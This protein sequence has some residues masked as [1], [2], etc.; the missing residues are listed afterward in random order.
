VIFVIT[1]V[2]FVM[3][4]HVLFHWYLLLD[5]LQG[6]SPIDA[7]PTNSIPFARAPGAFDVEPD[8]EIERR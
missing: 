7:V 6:R 4:S 8:V 2:P 3:P 1:R 5:Q